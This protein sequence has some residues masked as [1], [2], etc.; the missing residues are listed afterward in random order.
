MRKF[1]AC[2]I[3]FAGSAAIFLPAHAVAT[4]TPS[5]SN[6][7]SSSTCVLLCFDIYRDDVLIVSNAD[8]GMV[9]KYCQP[10]PI[11]PLQIDQTFVCADGH[12]EIRRVR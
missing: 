6:A 1:K 3:V 12:T 2:L 10:L 8:L 5:A 9:A 4:A 11:V 7:L